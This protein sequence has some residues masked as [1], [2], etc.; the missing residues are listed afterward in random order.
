[1]T[2]EIPSSE[3]N[4]RFPGREF[5]SVKCD[6]KSDDEVFHAN[7]T[8]NLGKMAVQAGI[9]EC[10]WRPEENG[11]VRAGQIIPRLKCGI[12]LMESNPDVFEKFNA[13]NGWG[14]YDQFLPWLKELL[15]ACEEFPWAEIEVS[16]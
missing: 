10:I 14:T 8:H 7:I 5:V 4:K 3:W 12:D 15:D 2:K 1:M 11:F 16:R 9:Y 6:S 13:E